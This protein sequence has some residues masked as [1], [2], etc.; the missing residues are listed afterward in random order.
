MD[1]PNYR[2]G[3]GNRQR[4]QDSQRREK[5][6]LHDLYHGSVEGLAALAQKEANDLKARELDLKERELKLREGELERLRTS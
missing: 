4:L 3:D 6:R 2:Q 1:D 5:H